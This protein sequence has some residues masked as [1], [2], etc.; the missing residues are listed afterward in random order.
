MCQ[1]LH[2]FIFHMVTD[3]YHSWDAGLQ[4]SAPHSQPTCAKN[5][6]KFDPIN[7]SCETPY[8][9]YNR[10]IIDTIC[11]TLRNTLGALQEVSVS[12]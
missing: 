3:R 4:N 1:L 11:P 2:V 12:Y 8:G 10:G 6:H 5:G 9:H 7:K